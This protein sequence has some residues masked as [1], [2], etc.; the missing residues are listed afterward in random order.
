MGVDP[1]WLQQIVATPRSFTETITALFVTFLVIH[2]VVVYQRR[3]H[4]P[5]GPW[6]WP[7]VGNLSVLNGLAHRKLQK[8][9]TR[10]GGLMYIQLGMYDHY[11]FA[12]KNRSDS[13]FLLLKQVS[14]AYI[15]LTTFI[16]EFLRVQ[17]LGSR[18]LMS[19]PQIH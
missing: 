9:A 17:N 12:V 19:L 15:V 16:V 4:L 18:L 1:M 5:P 7:V 2:L 6:P 3:Q 14:L 10:Y 13:V 11:S 8:L